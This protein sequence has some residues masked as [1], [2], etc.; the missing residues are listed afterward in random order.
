MLQIP[1]LQVT[2]R[3]G[4][5]CGTSNVLMFLKLRS[6]CNMTRHGMKAAA[7]S[8]FQMRIQSDHRSK[9]YSEIVDLGCHHSYRAQAPNAYLIEG[10]TRS[11]S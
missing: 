7:E 3:I 1:R 11:I 4:S 6:L 5:G 2:G 9:C 10:E 8:V